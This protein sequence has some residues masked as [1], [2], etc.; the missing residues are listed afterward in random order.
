MSKKKKKKKSDIK[1]ELDSKPFFE[2]IEIVL[3]IM[4]IVTGVIF[5]IIYWYFDIEYRLK[6]IE[7]KPPLEILANEHVEKLKLEFTKTNCNYL[8][9]MSDSIQNLIISKC[10]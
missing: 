2:R 6:K 7:E 9:E 10:H 8:Y 1:K 4:A 5:T 3:S